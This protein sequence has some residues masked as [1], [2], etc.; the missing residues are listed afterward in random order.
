[1]S[2]GT[3]GREGPPDEAY[4][5]VTNPE[6][7]RP[8]HGAALRLV[9]RLVADYDVEMTEGYDLS[10]LGIGKERLVRPSVKLSLDDITCAP[11]T[12]A[13]DD[14]PG[15][16]IGVGR[17]KEVGFPSCGCDACDEDADGEIARMTRA[18][19]SVVAGGFREAVRIPRFFGDGWLE[20]SSLTPSG[21]VTF[22]K[23]RV[24][25]SRALEM[26]GGHLYLEYDWK[27]WPRSQ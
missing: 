1:M 10:V 3:W 9:E 7:F 11:L 15:V 12:V 14:F 26:T 4:S 16:S 24:E 20:E 25:R 8:L 5:R 17:W 2:R 19:D 23:S 13:F 6:R 27:P 21:W 22:S 18:F